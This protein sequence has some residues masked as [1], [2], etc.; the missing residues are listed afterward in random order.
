MTNQRFKLFTM[1]IALTHPDGDVELV[2]LP[3]DAKVGHLRVIV[4]ERYEHFEL[5]LEGERLIDDEVFFSELSSNEVKI[6]DC[7]CETCLLDLLKSFGD[8]TI[9]HK[10]ETEEEGMTALMFAAQC[11]TIEMLEAILSHNPDIDKVN[12]SGWTALMF[13]IEH[14]T[15]EMVE[16]I[17][18]HD[19][20]HDI[21][22]SD[23]YGMTSLMFAACYGTIDTVRSILSR[24]PDVNKV[25][26]YA[27]TALMFAVDHGT[28]D[29]IQAIKD[30]SSK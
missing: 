3:T 25:T 4:K 29:M 19:P 10:I 8:E 21:D 16:A 23:I 22:K 20:N 17:L 6:D 11:G 7:S 24:G 9:N 28:I 30:Y 26:L 12:E 15:V 27:A 1:E 13:A 2:D 18:D 5:S 14:G